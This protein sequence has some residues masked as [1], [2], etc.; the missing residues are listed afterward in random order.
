MDASKNTALYQVNTKGIY[1]SIRFEAV[2]ATLKDS[3]VTVF[4]PSLL[5]TPSVS[6]LFQKAPEHLAQGL[7]QQAGNSKLSAR[8]EG[9]LR[10]HPL[11]VINTKHVICP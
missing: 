4:G 3:S 9:N 7:H 6:H 1:H 11:N 8:L 5:D 10:H 2:S